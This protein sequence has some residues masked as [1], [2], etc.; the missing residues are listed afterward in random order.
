[1]IVACIPAFN[2]EKTIGRVIIQAQKK[3]DE[4]IVCD[5]GSDDMTGEIAGRLGAIVLRH[6]KNRGYGYALRSLFRRSRMLD[7]DIMVT[8]DADGQHDPNVIPDLIRPIVEGKADVVIGSRF[9]G[10]KSHIPAY[11]RLGI[12]ILTRVQRINPEFGITDSQSGFRAYSKRA[13][14]VIEPTEMGMGAGAEL[15][16]KAC[17]NN[18]IIKEVPVLVRYDVEDPSSLNAVSH[19][20]EV[21]ASIIKH[22]SIRH[23]L[24]FY[25]LPGLLLTLTGLGFGFWALNIFANEKFFATS[26]VLLAIGSLTVG[27]LLSMTGII[28]FTL[29]NVFRGQR[30]SSSNE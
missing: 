3:V 23:P 14:T 29:I 27:L 2:E 7:A 6:E 21:I 22:S 25:G 19:A 24:L 20:F 13:L 12:N 18:L 28:L 8:L 4:V 5:D 15:V 1:M 30:V 9:L 10:D 16:M 17:D 26:I 11:R